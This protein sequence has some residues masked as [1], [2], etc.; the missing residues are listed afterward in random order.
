M[1][2]TYSMVDSRN[3]LWIA[4]DNGINIYNPLKAEILYINKT[5]GLPSEQVVS[6]VEDNEGNVWAGTR[7]GLACVYVKVDTKN[8]GYDF[9]VLSFDENDGLVN[10]IFNQNAVFKNAQGD[11]YFGGTKGYT[12]FNPQNIRFNKSVPAPRITGLMIANEEVLPGRMFRKRVVL[13]E[14]VVS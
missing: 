6:L 13:D 2:V 7:N 4:T 10:T 5:N 9:N 12:V 8:A 11:I 3:L 1:V 14:S